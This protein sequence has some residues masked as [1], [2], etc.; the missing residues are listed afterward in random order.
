MVEQTCNDSHQLFV[1][2][3][4]FNPHTVE[5]RRRVEAALAVV[6]EPLDGQTPG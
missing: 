3:Q 2:L 5:M 1:D 4:R 6:T